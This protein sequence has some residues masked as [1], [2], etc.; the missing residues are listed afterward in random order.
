MHLGDYEDAAKWLSQSAVANPNFSMAHFF[1]A[2]ALAQL[3]RLKEAHSEAQAGLALNPTFAIS[4]F[5]DDAESQNPTSLNS[6][7]TFT[8]ACA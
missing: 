5:R 2:A 7:T 6:V 4:R 8:K 1:F 3:G